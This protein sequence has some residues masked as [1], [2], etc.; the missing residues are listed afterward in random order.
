MKRLLVLF[1]VLCASTGYAKEINT[2]VMATSDGYA[3][4]QGKAVRVISVSYKAESI[5]DVKVYNGDTQ[6][7]SLEHVIS[8][9]GPFDKDVAPI[10]TNGVRLDF[11]G[12]TA[13]EATV[14]YQQLE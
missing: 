10:F 3:T 8:T 14:V 9:F 7:C 6:I 12:I 5:G 4:T 1:L 13:K 11:E 2:V